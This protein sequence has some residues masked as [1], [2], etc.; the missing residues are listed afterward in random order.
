MNRF[1]LP[2]LGDG[3]GLRPVHYSH[4]YNIPSEHWGVDWFEI[5]SEDYF[6]NRGPMLEFI[7]ERRPIVMHGV[8]LNIG[9]ADPLDMGYLRK[10][11]ALADRIKPAWISDHL[12]WTGVNGINSHDLWPVPLTADCHAHIVQRVRAVQDYLGRPLIL[13]NPSSYLDWQCSEISEWEFLAELVERAGCGLLLDVNNVHVSSVNHGFD[14]VAYINGLPADAIVYVHIAGSADHGTYRIDTH[15][16]PVA[17]PVW[18]LYRLAWQ[19]T[20]GVST[21][22]EWDANIPP[23]ETLTAELAKAKKCRE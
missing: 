13:E 18:P 7:R 23:F 22:L 11:A 20:G 17:D 14:P 6:D 19:R 3:V 9:S 16:R 12:C 8:S 5:I 4:L 21:L 10:L 1:G 2:N 15:D